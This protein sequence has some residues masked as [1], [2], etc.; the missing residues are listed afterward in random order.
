MN[1]K[2]YLLLYLMVLVLLFIHL[3][4]NKFYGDSFPSFVFPSFSKAERVKET[5][6]IPTINLYAVDVNND[7]VLLN[8]KT[9]LASSV[10]IHADQV[11]KTIKHKEQLFIKQSLPT[12]IDNA[13]VKFSKL[14]TQ[15]DQ[16]RFFLQSNLGKQYP[17]KA[18]KSVLIVEGTQIYNVRTRKLSDTLLEKETTSIPLQ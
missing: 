4:V 12:S 14:S 1:R 10:M 5:Y 2:K 18:F 7:T 3:A 9:A 8:K 11:L 17:A 6:R 13:S 15:R 16:F